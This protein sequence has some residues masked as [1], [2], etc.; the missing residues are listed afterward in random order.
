MD[1][2][3]LQQRSLLLYCKNRAYC[4]NLLLILFL[5]WNLLHRGLSE[6]FHVLLHSTKHPPPPHICSLLIDCNLLHQRSLS[7]M[8]LAQ[9]SHIVFPPHA[10]LWLKGMLRQ[11]ACRKKSS[12]GERKSLHIEKMKSSC[13][14]VSRG[15]ILGSYLPSDWHIHKYCFRSAF[16]IC[17]SWSSLFDECGSRSKSRLKINK[18]VSNVKYNFMF[19]SNKAT[20]KQFIQMS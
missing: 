17:G 12:Q 4:S 6:Q 2:N 14:S 11:F 9:K 16:I 20:C 1:Y 10:S 19:S 13:Q 18:F 5:V 15:R 8:Y 3:L 7:V